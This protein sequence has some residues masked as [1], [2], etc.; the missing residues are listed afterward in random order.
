VD[1]CFPGRRSRTTIGTQAFKYFRA[2][3]RKDRRQRGGRADK[4]KG[5]RQRVSFVKGLV[6]GRWTVQ[7][8][9]IPPADA[10]WQHRKEQLQV[11]FRAGAACR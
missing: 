3:V 9:R 2:C 5:Q 10:I 4:V 8:V 6:H 1:G 7:R 11:Y